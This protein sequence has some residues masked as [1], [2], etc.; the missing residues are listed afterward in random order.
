M[1]AGA[2]ACK[3]DVAGVRTAIQQMKATVED[4]WRPGDV[5]PHIEIRIAAARVIFVDVTGRRDV[6]VRI[7][8]AIRGDRSVELNLDAAVD[9]EMGTVVHRQRERGTDRRVPEITRR[10]RSEEHTSKLP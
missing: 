1:G 3:L 5:C 8:D 9:R 10:G 4:R 2:T 7:A 6:D